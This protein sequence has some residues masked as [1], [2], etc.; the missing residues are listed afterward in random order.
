MTLRGWIALLLGLAGPAAADSFVHLDRRVTDSDLHRAVACAAEPGGDCTEPM[1]AWPAPQRRALTVS[2]QGDG[3][4]P[5]HAQLGRALDR[6]VAQINRVGA[7]LRLRRV[8]DGAEA[9]IMLW[10]S[11]I[12]EGEPIM[13]PEAG[14]DGQET[15][16]GARV[17]LWWDDNHTITHGAIVIAADLPD[18]DL[19]SVVLEEMVQSLGLLTDL[20][21]PAYAMT[22]IFSESSNTVTR[23][24]GQDAAVV[25]LH[26]PGE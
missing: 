7:D 13:L 22:S 23:L 14:F 9:E 5:R 1:A 10:D 12:A 19:R 11:D 24:S 4:G 26:Y 18:G 20:T 2:L 8:G 16:E 25:R 6:A 3:S 17:N 15:M 21:G